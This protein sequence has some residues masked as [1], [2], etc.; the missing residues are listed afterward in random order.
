MAVNMPKLDLRLLVVFDA[1]MKERSVSK[2]ALR[3]NLTQ[4]AVSN[5]LNRLRSALE[6]R[7]APLA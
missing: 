4:A 3:L 5:S 2:A 7:R 6:D 1:V